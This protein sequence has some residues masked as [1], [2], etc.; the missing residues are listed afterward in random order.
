MTCQPVNCLQGYGKA[1]NRVG[2]ARPRKRK[3]EVAETMAEDGSEVDC[4]TGVTGPEQP[5][6]DNAQQGA[7]SQ[8]PTVGPGFKQWKAALQAFEE[9][10]HQ[11]L[12]LRSCCKKYEDAAKLA[13]R[14]FDAKMRRLEA[15]DKLKRRKKAVGAAKRTYE[16]IIALNEAQL[17]AAWSGREAAE[18]ERDAAQAELR[19]MEFE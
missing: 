15:G 12:V 17:K 16:A 2:M 4:D 18:A 8:D 7:R 11:A 1:S 5:A 6:L 9:K 3:V 13:Q 14:L 19:V 10:S